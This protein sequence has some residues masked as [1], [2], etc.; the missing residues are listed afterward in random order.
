MQLCKY[1]LGRTLISNVRQNRVW[2]LCWIGKV[3]LFRLRWDFSSRKIKIMKV[4]KQLIEENLPLPKAGMQTISTW[5]QLKIRLNPGFCC[6]GGC[7]GCLVQSRL[8]HQTRKTRFDGFHKEALSKEL[9]FQ[10]KALMGEFGTVSG[11]FVL[12]SVRNHEFFTD[13]LP[14]KYNFFSLLLIFSPWKS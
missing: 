12:T 9:R 14:C 11:H 2:Q 7:Q 8:L 6:F 4:D 3:H 5:K 13:Y 1:N 10:G